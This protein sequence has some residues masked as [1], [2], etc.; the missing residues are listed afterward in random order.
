M[1]T[2][3]QGTL[4]TLHSFNNTDGDQ[5][6]GGLVQAPDGILYG[7]TNEGGTSDNCGANCGTV[8]RLLPVRECATCRAMETRSLSR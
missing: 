6:E 4:T 2:R 8:F 7:T 5:P 1:F 3:R